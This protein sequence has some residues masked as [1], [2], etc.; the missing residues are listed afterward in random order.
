ME[1]VK[2]T[3]AGDEPFDARNILISLRYALSEE[4]AT[5]EK[6]RDDE[7]KDGMD[8]DHFYNRSDYGEKDT[9][10][11]DMS[12]YDMEAMEILRD[13]THFTT[14]DWRHIPDIAT[15][16]P[17]LRKLVLKERLGL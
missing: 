2:S 11:D 7:N 8:D 12:Q 6:E 13:T 1:K 10:K 16:D 14:Q 9:Y 17:E 15:Q 3:K 4:D 5:S